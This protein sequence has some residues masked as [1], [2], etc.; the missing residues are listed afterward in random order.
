[1]DPGS[2]S[3]WRVAPSSSSPTS[4]ATVLGLFFF[5]LAKGWRSFASLG[6]R[7]LYASLFGRRRGTSRLV[8][9]G[10]LRFLFLSLRVGGRYSFSIYDASW[11]G[12][13]LAH[14]AFPC[15]GVARGGGRWIHLGRGARRRRPEALEPG[16][17]MG[18]LCCNFQ[19]VQGVLCKIPGMYCASFLI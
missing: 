19:F 3:V 13:A 18:M 4:S 9:G 16:A 11:S 17:L 15:C 2:S 14:A 5:V 12:Q 10:G 8:G 7:P 6:V 1:V